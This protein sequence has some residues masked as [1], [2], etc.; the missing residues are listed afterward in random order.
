MNK[1][2]QADLQDQTEKNPHYL[3]R[4]Y[5]FG[6]NHERTDIYMMD[7]GTICR[8]GNVSHMTQCTFPVQWYTLH[9]LVSGDF[10][11]ICIGRKLLYSWIS[12][13]LC[14]FCRRSSIRAM[15]RFPGLFSPVLNL[16]TPHLWISDSGRKNHQAAGPSLFCWPPR[17]SSP[18]ARAAR[19]A[20]IT[21]A[22][23]GFAPPAASPSCEGKKK[24]KRRRKKHNIA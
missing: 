20:V 23:S 11:S 3:T 2:M 7:Y 15:P 6:H 10:I 1:H 16:S 4:K 12:F 14:R 19:S 13:P 22:A 9:R 5:S 18:A 8:Q 17:P 24:R 21:D